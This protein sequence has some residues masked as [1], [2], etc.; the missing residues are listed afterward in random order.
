MRLA[1]IFQD[2]MVIQREKP[3]KIWGTGEENEII[4]VTVRGQTLHTQVSGGIWSLTFPPMDVALGMEISVKSADSMILI[5]DVAVGEVWLAG[6][7]SN[8]E[9]FMRYD[10]DYPAER[11]DCDNEYIHFFDYPELSYPEQ[12]KD[13]D[14]SE[15]GFW[16]T[17]TSK[18]LEYFSAAAYYFAK[19]LYADMK[20]PI[21]VI[22]CNWGGTSA[23]C[24]MSEKYLN[25]HGRIWVEDYQNGLKNLYLET[26]KADYRKN[27]M[28]DTGNPFGNSFTDMV[29]Y[30]T[31]P[32]QQAELMK[33][34]PPEEFLM[35]GP[36]SP[37]RPCGLYH[38][39]LEH[40]APYGIRGFLWYQ[41]E[42]DDIHAEIYEDVLSDLID[43]WREL[44]GEELPFLC[45]Q[46]APFEKWLAIE[47]TRY[48]E[49]RKAQAHVAEKKK[50]VYLISSSDAGMQYDIHPK[51]KQ[52][53]GKRLADSAKGHVYG[54]NV[55]CDA[56]KCSAVYWK[57]D[58]LNLEFANAGNRL[59]IE[60]DELNAFT[61]YGIRDHIRERLGS[62]DYTILLNGNLVVA[63]QLKK[64][65]YPV[66]E[67]Q[68]AETAYYEVNLYN[69]NGIPAIPFTVRIE[70]S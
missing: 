24:W 10:A 15:F 28:N 53:I 25:R 45:V 40:V 8:M 2:H 67:I 31:T 26:Y 6:G 21:G 22:G 34:V 68:F 5:T 58:N 62:E 9:F 32:E 14:Y 63:E 23:G 49:V 4:D 44:W 69:E 52:P 29:M 13:F 43:C 64:T 42:S 18:D 39:M 11:V 57:G 30:G 33:N 70:V 3:F 48:P 7:Q 56:P 41:G 50:N 38:T 61:V 51:K 27:P 65:G 37:H 47:G 1:R 35:I 12:E 46:L 19:E 36:Y 55:L 59:R 54:K 66:Y 20:V 17:C 60:G 16:R